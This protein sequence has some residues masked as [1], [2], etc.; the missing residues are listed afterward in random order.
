LTDKP[1]TFRTDKKTGTISQKNI[2]IKK[3]IM[4]PKICISHHHST[5]SFDHPSEISSLSPTFHNQTC[6]IINQLVAK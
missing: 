6:G 5:G 4:P 3:I 2:N 1:Q